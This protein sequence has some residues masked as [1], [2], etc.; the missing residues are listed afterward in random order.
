MKNKLD[1]KGFTLIELLTVIGIIAILASVVMVMLG[2]A[3]ESG[4]MAANI[5]FEANILHGIGDQLAGEWKF[6]T[7]D[8]PTSDTSSFGSNG[9]LVGSPVWD[10]VAGYNGKGS[11][12]FNGSNYIRTTVKSIGYTNNLTITAWV[13]SSNA[14]TNTLDGIVT[15]GRNGGGGFSGFVTGP[16][17]NLEVAWANGNWSPAPNAGISMPI[18]KWNFIAMSVSPNKIILY[19]NDKKYTYNGTFSTV[20]LSGVNDFYIGKEIAQTGWKGLIDNVR[21]YSST[22]TALDIQNIYAEGLK[23]HQDLAVR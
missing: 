4:R 20:N 6:D 22:Y 19:M 16:A 10:A 3:K 14:I 15:F 11:Y 5:Q 1:T 2:S 9:T 12:L 21:V 8:S 17:N 18:G 13:K 23:T 7:N